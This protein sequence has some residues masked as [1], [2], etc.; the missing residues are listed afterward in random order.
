[1]VSELELTSSIT[2]VEQELRKGKLILP[3]KDLIL[4]SYNENFIPK[5]VIIG[6]DPY[7]SGKI[8]YGRFV[9][10]STGIAFECSTIDKSQSLET[11]QKLMC[12]DNKILTGNDVDYKS[13]P[14]DL[15]YLRSQHVMLTN[16]CLTVEY[17]KPGSHFADKHLGL[18]ISPMWEMFTLKNMNHLSYTYYD[19]PIV[20]ILCGL[21]AYSV[22]TVI[23][24][25]H[26]A[27][28]IP[29]PARNSISKFKNLN[30]FVTANRYLESNRCS[31][32]LWAI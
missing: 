30:P 26:L 31:G 6:Q 29:H 28:K 24:P 21:Y 32:I 17:G 23:H 4:R 19:R 3:Y 20:F 22:S 16:M 5:V 10:Y 14:N 1:M 25:N 27:I 2:F 15:S 13:Q 7:Y 18:E 12:I 8:E 9:P 11:L